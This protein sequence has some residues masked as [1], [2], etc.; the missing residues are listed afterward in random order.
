MLTKNKTKHNNQTIQ[1]TQEQ[2][3]T[4]SSSSLYYY[5]K[6]HKYNHKMTKDPRQ[7]IQRQPQAP[8][9]PEPLLLLTKKPERV[10]RFRSEKSIQKVHE[11]TSRKD[12]KQSEFVA[13]WGQQDEQQKMRQALKEEIEAYAYGLILD[14]DNDDSFTSIGIK[15]KFGTRKQQ[16]Q[17][18]KEDAWS[19][20]LWEQY[21][22]YEDQKAA[23]KKGATVVAYNDE[24]LAA[25]YERASRKAGKRA[26]T[27]AILVEMEVRGLLLHRPRKQ[28]KQ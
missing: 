11:V 10:V 7:S 9:E 23:S 21:Y 18:A 5:T 15:D 6:R 13:V 12:Y 4:S 20:V 3:S 17:Q 24:L 14:D 1:K 8:Q 22:Q 28:E 2:K 27:E 26:Q 19:A 16:K 25:A